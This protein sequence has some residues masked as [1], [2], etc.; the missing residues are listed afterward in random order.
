MGKTATF[1]MF[2]KVCKVPL[3]LFVL[4]LTARYFGTDIEKDIYLL[5]FSAITFLDGVL[6]GPF[7]ETFR[8]K[9]V[10]LKEEKSEKIALK[11]TQSFLSFF[12]VISFFIIGVIFL[13][14]TPIAQYLN[15]ADSPDSL[16]LVKKMLTY[17]TPI[18]LI[19]LLV[20]V[21][22]SI[23]N[24][25]G[26]FY[27]PE[28]SNMISSLINIVIIYLVVHNVGIYSL[29]IAHYVSNLILLLIIIYQISRRRIPLFAKKWNFR[30][31]GF[32]IYFLFAIP[33]F[34]PFFASQLNT[35]LE[36]IFS[37]TLGIGALSTL[38]FSNKLPIMVNGMFYNLIAALLI[39]EL[40]KFFIRKEKEAFAQSLLTIWH[41]C[42]LAIGFYVAYVAGSSLE[43]A[44]VLFG[45]NKIPEENL[46]QIANLSVLYA[47]SSFSV[48]TY[49]ILGAV[50]LSSQQQKVYA[51]L[52]VMTQISIIGINC[53]VF[54]FDSIYIF[55][56]SFLF[57]HA[58]SSFIMLRRVPFKEQVKWFDIRYF[59]MVLLQI[60]TAVVWRYLIQWFDNDYVNL[61]V[62]FLVLSLV[63]ILGMFLLRVDEIT[64]I[65]NYLR[66]KGMKRG[67]FK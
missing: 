19:N 1:L 4:Y 30:F 3:Q 56:M 17:V 57:S 55:P 53:L 27:I 33:F 2:L 11:Q 44:H 31:E 21:G 66:R 28:V 5:C 16:Q 42:L 50:L 34:F 52:A 37:K 38:D 22:T 60:F 63:T 14:S 41:F 49:Y 51:F 7:Y 6:W 13:F 32:K 9:F 64:F 48:L 67:L 24:A 36:K 35:F 58:L 10:S 47:F 46:M 29:I 54:V 18:L 39:P 40:T 65:K 20:Q 43:I 61:G 25:Y 26:I 12:F 62:N 8:V 45:S 23:L 15:P 59:M